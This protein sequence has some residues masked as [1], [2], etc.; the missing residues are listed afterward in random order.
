MPK[1]VRK[2]RREFANAVG[3]SEMPKGV[4]KCHREFGNA[5]GNSETRLRVRS[6]YLQLA[7]RLI[8]SRRI[9]SAVAA[10]K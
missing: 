4:R 7:L 9:K 5:I 2:R 8:S 10:L 1:G 6:D 3:S